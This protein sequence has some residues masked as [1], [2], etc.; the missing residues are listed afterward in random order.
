[1]LYFKYS[2]PSGAEFQL[3]ERL[4]WIPDLGTSYSVGLDGIGLWL[5]LL[6]TFL[7]AYCGLGRLKRLKT[8]VR[9]YYFLLLALE[10]GMLGAFVSLD[11]FLFYIFWE[12]M[13]IPMYFLIGIWGGKDRIYAAMKFFL[14]TLVGS[15][16]MLVAI[17]YLS[18]QH[19]VQIGH[20]STH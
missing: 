10:T 20:Y 15:L 7:D 12:A 3:T 6:T 13:L 19:K 17:F 11:M 4:E 16:L 1:M 8:R 9:E 18:Y 14:Y 5:I 2:Q